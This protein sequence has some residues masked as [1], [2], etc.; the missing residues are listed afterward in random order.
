MDLEQL[1][2]QLDA[3]ADG[4]LDRAALEAWLDGVLGADALGAERSDSA[5]WDAAPD[6][7]R[8]FWRL[9]YLFDAD[10]AEDQ[11]AERTRA[12]R[13]L[14]CLYATRSASAT[15]ELLPILLD[16]ER[17]CAIVDKHQAGVISRTGFLSVI[18]ESGYPPHVKLWLE[19]AHAD[20][21]ARLCARLTAGEY[22]A[23]AA[24]FER[25]PA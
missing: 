3:F 12:G 10:P 7:E 6:E 11:D 21:L 20:A 1:V 15:F 4:R 8:L 16:Q 14:A 19:H 18:A 5:P 13:I 25:P 23:A 24:A 9:V 17:F 22:D 2:R